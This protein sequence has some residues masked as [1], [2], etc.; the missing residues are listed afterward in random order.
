MYISHIQ[1]DIYAG[2]DIYLHLHAC[3]VNAKLNMKMY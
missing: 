3:Q 1:A 2:M